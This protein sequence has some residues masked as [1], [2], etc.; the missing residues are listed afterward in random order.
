MNPM[1]NKKAAIPRTLACKSNEAVFRTLTVGNAG[2]LSQDKK[3]G[4]SI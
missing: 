3:K 2:E 4:F 1:D